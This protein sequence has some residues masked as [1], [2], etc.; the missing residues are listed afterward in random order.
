VQRE[1]DPLEVAGSELF[2]TCLQIFQPMSTPRE[3]LAEELRGWAMQYRTYLSVE[4][5]VRAR[6]SHLESASPDIE[7]APGDFLMTTI[8]ASEQLD[9]ATGDAQ[10]LGILYS[11]LAPLVW[12]WRGLNSELVGS[13]D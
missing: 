9:R 13:V 4:M 5:V 2:S 3:T 10:C 8:V 6:S 7:T 11:G 1:R 12:Q